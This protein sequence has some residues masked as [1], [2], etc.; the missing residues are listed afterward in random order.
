MSRKDY[1]VGY[2]HPPF[3]SQFKPGQSGNKKGRRKKTLTMADIILEEL[4]KTQVI[5][6][7]G[8]K[9]RISNLELFVKQLIRLSLK[10]QPRPL[11][12]VF[13]LLEEGLSRKADAEQAAWC[14]KLPDISKMTDEERTKLYFETLKAMNRK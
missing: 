6:K 14:A 1:V 12:L 7:A 4:S 9:T 13:E 11:T 10:G 3:H 5:E 8:K 2:K